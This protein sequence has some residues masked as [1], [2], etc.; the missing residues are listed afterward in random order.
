VNRDL[1]FV[2]QGKAPE[3]YDHARAADEDLL[4]VSLLKID[5]LVP[6]DLTF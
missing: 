3:L 2:D 4:S 1:V 6:V 5:D